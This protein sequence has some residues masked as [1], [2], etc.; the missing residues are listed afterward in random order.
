MTDDPTV[1]GHWRLHHL[2]HCVI[3]AT[4]GYLRFCD[5]SLYCSVYNGIFYL[6][7]YEEDCF[8]GMG[9][10]KRHPGRSR[11]TCSSVKR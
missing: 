3:G 8:K 4:L 10:K 11:T 1:I 5:S 6:E 2:S 7:A 9:G